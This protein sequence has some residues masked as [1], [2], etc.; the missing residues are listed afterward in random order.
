MNTTA[1]ADYSSD[2]DDEQLEHEH[3]SS[4]VAT[5]RL[6]AYPAT[7]TSIKYF[8][9]DK[10]VWEQRILDASKRAHMRG[11]GAEYDRTVTRMHIL[12]IWVPT[13]YLGTPRIEQSQP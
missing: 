12:G 3:A 9:N 2:D 10:G 8:K 5:G 13:D 7:I 6:R 4:F 1:W 11:L